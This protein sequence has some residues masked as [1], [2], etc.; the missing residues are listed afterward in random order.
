MTSTSICVR[1][2]SMK[3]SRAGSQK[4]HDLRTG[5]VPAYVDKS[6]SH[7]NT[8]PILLEQPLLKTTDEN[9]LRKSRKNGVVG[10][11][12]IITFSTAAQT[13]VS[14]LSPSEQDE[15]FT[16][17]AVNS[18]THFGS[19]C[20][21]LS[22]HRDESAIHAHFTFANVNF[23]TQK[24]I[25]PN[26]TSL[27]KLQDVAAQAAREI[28]PEIIRGKSKIQRIR[29][30]EKRSAT[31]HRSVKQ[32]HEDLPREIESMKSQQSSLNRGLVDL[33]SRLQSTQEKLSTIDSTL[34]ERT[35]NLQKTENRLLSA[36]QKLE[37]AL[38]DE[39]ASSKNIEKLKKRVE[40]YE[41]R[42]P[43]Q[44]KE[45]ASLN[46]EKNKLEQQIQPLRTE[47]N[48][49]EKAISNI[50]KNQ[51][52]TVPVLVKHTK[53]LVGHDEVIVQSQQ[54]V[55]PNQHA[56]TRENLKKASVATKK[57]RDE[58]SK[59]LQIICENRQYAFC[60]HANFS[61]LKIYEIYGCELLDFGRMIIAKNDGTAKQIAAALYSQTR[62]KCWNP[63]IFKCND[64][65]ANEII[66]L[67]K[68]DN[69][70]CKN[71]IKIEFKSEH[72]NSMLKK[73]MQQ[74]EPSVSISTSV[75]TGMSKFFKH[76][77]NEPDEDAD[78]DMGMGI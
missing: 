15:L 37:K 5:K 41:L 65:V 2:E 50:P 35:N 36:Q 26:A 54:F 3:S 56:R 9:T 69:I 70:L 31:I 24:R 27:K 17:V 47:K 38:S 53:K 34:R 72:Q 76:I 74:T 75:D 77:Q 62:K 13:L 59:M 67:A 14:R 78:D 20:E 60:K 22:I 71:G 42:I 18:S 29:D 40:T 43:E 23:E 32:L 39:N 6:R 30:G 52:K 21:S 49:L 19:R 8:N 68:A 48:N 33:Q 12:G 28:L 73:A 25:N 10:F 45:I 16:K 58:R 66:K 7:L 51:F 46:A 64:S 44:H 55:T 11:A 1:I 57:M 63:A 61:D 4:S